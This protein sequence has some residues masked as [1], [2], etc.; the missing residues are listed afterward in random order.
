MQLL[1]YTYK[2]ENRYGTARAGGRIVVA[3]GPPDEEGDVDSHI[4][5]SQQTFEMLLLDTTKRS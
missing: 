5:R 4:R 3:H 2:I 1:D